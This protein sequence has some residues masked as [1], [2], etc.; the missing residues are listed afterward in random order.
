MS[1]VTPKAELS[2]PALTRATR[3]GLRQNSFRAIGQAGG[4]ADRGTAARHVAGYD[5]SGADLGKIADADVAD[6][7]CAGAQQHASAD[8]RSS[9]RIFRAPPDRDVLHDRHLVADGDESA[10]H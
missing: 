5:R 7:R 3:S 9:V 10:D 1:A 4:N 6:D 8:P 2:A